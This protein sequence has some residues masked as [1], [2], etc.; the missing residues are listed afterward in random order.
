MISLISRASRWI[1]RPGLAI[2]IVSLAGTALAKVAIVPKWDRFE[3]SFKSSVEYE[4]PF[5]QCTLRATFVSPSG[6]TNVV[7]GFWDGGKTWRIRFSPDQLGRWTYHTSCSDLANVRLNDQSG[8]FLCTSSVG[9]SRFAQHGPVRL[10]RDRIHF[11]HADGSPFFW[12]ADVAW[13]APRLSTPKEWILYTQTRGGQNFSAVE[14]AATSGLDVKMHSAFSGQTRIRIDPE[15]FQGLDEKV[16]MMN[17]AGLLSVIAPFWGSTGAT[18]DLPENQV[19]LLVRYMKARWGAYDVAWLLTPEE[20]HTDR[21]LRIG[22][23]V[24]AGAASGP[25]ILFPGPLASGYDDFQN[26]DWIDA[27]G[28]GTGQNISNDSIAW[29]ISGPLHREATNQPPRP[30]INV[31]PPLEN[32]FAAHSQERITTDDVRRVA[33]WSLLLTPAA[34]VSYG[35]QDVATWNAARQDKLP[36][37]Q[38]SLFLP[39]AKQMTGVADFVSSA[40]YPR[41]QPAYRTLSVQPGRNAPHRYAAA[42]QTADK[43]L[44]VAYVPEDRA[45]EMFIEALPP[46]PN[47]QWL[48][49]RTGQKIAAVAVVGTR[50]CQFPTPDTGDWVLTIKTGK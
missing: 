29:L 3:Q 41:L 6:E 32:G 2:C 33:W 9:K 40:G 22:R 20:N 35:A 8:E 14:W 50:T 28:F 39:G 11:E 21:W 1:A 17:R 42:A 31:L 18:N 48:N 25:V 46:S 24:F 34:G 38:L 5:Q 44:T 13:N 12:M 30:I 4:N 43:S 47:I 27:F 49:P 26:E 10:T 36:T 15:Y 16:D 19:K 45:L 37:W 7:Y 23:E